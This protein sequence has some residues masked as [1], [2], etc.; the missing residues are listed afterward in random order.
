MIR[1]R[2]EMARDAAAKIEQATV[3]ERIVKAHG[4]MKERFTGRDVQAMSLQSLGLLPSLE[5]TTEEI[6]AANARAQKGVKIDREKGK[7]IHKGTGP[8]G[9]EKLQAQQVAWAK[10]MGVPVHD[11]ATGRRIG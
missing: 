6:H 10:A 1:H 8:T 7:R 5:P 2:M 9:M 4:R 3:Q 11:G